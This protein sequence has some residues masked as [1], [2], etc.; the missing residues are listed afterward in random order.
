MDG[1]RLKINRKYLFS[2]QAKVWLNIFLTYAIE[3]GHIYYSYSELQ[4]RIRNEL[5]LSKNE[6]LE[7]NTKRKFLSFDTNI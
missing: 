4:N 5:T 2:I 6:H 7:E 3:N 1:K